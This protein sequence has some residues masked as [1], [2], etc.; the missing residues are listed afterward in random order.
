MIRCA[1]LVIE[2]KSSDIL[3]VRVRDNQKWYLPGGKIEQNE[4]P[5]QALIR[6]LR[7]ELGI[8]LNINELHYL[9]TVIGQ[10]YGV[11]DNVELVCFTLNSIGE[12][13]PQAEISEVRFINWQNERELIAPAVLV[14]YDTFLNQNNI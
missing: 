4:E 1:C 8:S 5:R 9:T 10:A 3:L 11:D 14:L 2:N 6:E 12:I 13:K 7:E